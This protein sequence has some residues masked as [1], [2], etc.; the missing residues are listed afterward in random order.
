MVDYK[1][2]CEKQMDYIHDLHQQAIRM[3]W[4]SPSPDEIKKLQ[5]ENK[6][7]KEALA[8][9]ES[10]HSVKSKGA[11]EEEEFVLGQHYP[12]GIVG[13]KNLVECWEYNIGYRKKYEKLQEENKKLNEEVGGLTAENDRLDT[14]ATD[15][16]NEV[17]KLKEDVFL[18]R[19]IKEVARLKEENKE[20]EE[21]LL[22][23]MSL[24]SKDS[25]KLATLHNEKEELKEK[26]SNTMMDTGR[27]AE[28]IWEKDEENKK[29]KEKTVEHLGMAETLHDAVVEE[30]EKL[31]KHN[32]KLL[33]EYEE[34]CE[35][36]NARMNKE[37][38]EELKEDSEQYKSLVKVICDTHGWGDFIKDLPE[39]AIKTLREGGWDEDDLV[40]DDESDE[41]ILENGE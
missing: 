9:S 1:A 38:E 3:R 6:K 35:E 22:S 30:N 37:Q 28:T 13:M 23:L 14:M 17:K 33:E 27:L 25:E 40:F 20:Q 32:E 19:A 36:R 31:K 18:N 15:S 10:I 4:G 21:Q 24:R 41:D 26:L 12:P 39:H 16:A 8:V 29:L 34:V 7:L 5:E 11:G 2:L